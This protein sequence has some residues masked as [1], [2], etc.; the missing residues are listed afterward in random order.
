MVYS[1][2]RIKQQFNGLYRAGLAHH[3][4][5]G[6][7]AT[8]RVG[9]SMPHAGT[10]AEFWT[11]GGELGGDYS[12]NGCGGTETIVDGEQS[13]GWRYAW[14][15]EQ[16]WPNIFICSLPMV[17]DCMTCMETCMNGPLIGVMFNPRY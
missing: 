9:W 1:C 13:L 11:G 4:L 7:P 14:Y 3:R 16:R 10:T 15:W 8:H 12:S 6:V 5:L 2:A 17:L